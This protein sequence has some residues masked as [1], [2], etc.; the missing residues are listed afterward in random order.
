M[1]MQDSCSWRHKLC[2]H[3]TLANMLAHATKAHHLTEQTPAA[4][5]AGSGDPLKLTLL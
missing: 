3:L 5:K 2:V 1:L 4:A